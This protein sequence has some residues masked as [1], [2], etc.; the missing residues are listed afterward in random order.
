MQSVVSFANARA[1]GTALLLVSL[2]SAS[3]PRAQQRAANNRPG[4]QSNEQIGGH[5]AAAGRLIVKLRASATSADRDDIDARTDADVDRPIGN[6]PL[7][8]IH[9]RSKGVAALLAALSRNQQVEYAEPDYVVHASSDPNDPFFINQWGLSNTGQSVNG[10]AGLPGADVHATAAWEL[11]RGSANTVVGIVDGGFDVAHDDLAENVWAAPRAFSVEVAGMTVS[12][13]AGTHGAFFLSSVTCDPMYDGASDHATHVAGIAGAAGD[14]GQGVAGASWHTS[15]MSLNFM[16]DGSTGY[17]SDAINAIEFAIQVKAAFAGSAAGNI[18][19]LNNSWGSSAPSQALQD[20]IDRAGANDI[21]FVV[22]AGN[23]GANLDSA[24]DYPASFNRPNQLTV[25]ASAA[26]DSLASFSN[27]SSTSVHLAAPGSN[28]FS[29]LSGGSFGYMS[30]TSMAAPMVAGAAA[31]VLSR[32]AMSTADLKSLL[33]STVDV[34][35]AFEST[36][37]SGGRLNVE[38]ALQACTGSAGNAQPSVTL[39]APLDGTTVS[40][41]QAIHLAA[42]AADSD[43]SIARVDFFAGSSLVGSSAAPPYSITWTNPAPGTYAVTAVATDNAGM[44]TRSDVATVRVGASGSVGTLPSPWQHGDV[45][46]TAMSG[47]A[48]YANGTFTVQGTGDGIASGVSDGFQY[49]YQPLTAD[50][51]IVARVT[52]MQNVGGSAQ[53]GLAMRGGLNASAFE[54]VLDFRGDGAVEFAVR[55]TDGQTTS[56]INTASATMPVW[57]KLA[58]LQA[59]VYAYVSSDGTNW[60]SLGKAF[61][62]NAPAWVGIGV[63]NNGAGDLNAAAFDSVAV[64]GGAAPSDGATGT[65][66]PSSWI[67][68]DVGVTGQAGHASISNGI[69]TVS[70]AGSDIWGTSDS[71]Q[72][73][74]QNTSGDFTLTARIVSDEDTNT[75]AKAG[76]MLR[77]SLAA[78]AANVTLDIRPTGDVEFMT[79]PSTGASETFLG[80][81][82]QPLPG[83]VRL[84]RSGSTVTASASNDGST[85]TTVGS[86][87]FASANPLAGLVVC[88][89]TTSTLDTATFDNVAITPGSSGAALPAP[90]TSTDIGATGQAGHA[91][92]SNGVFTL[93]GAGSDIWGTTDSFQYVSQPVG[94]DVSIVARITGEQDTSAY[95]KAGI[96]LRDGFGANAANVILD[97]V[98]SGGVEFMTRGSDG[99]SET[100]LQTANL[101][102][103]AWVRL[104]VNSGTV[105]ADVSADGSQWTTLGSIPFASSALAGLLVCSHTTAALNTATFDNVSVGQAAALPAPWVSADVGQTGMTGSAAFASGTFTVRGAG[106]DIWGNADG[107]Q[108]VNQAVS[109]DFTLTAR[110]SNQQNT[111]T[112]AKAGIMLRDSLS[113]SGANVLLDMRPTG[114][115]EFMT[116]ASDGA[117][118]TY[119]GTASL[120]APAWV[121]LA[122]AGSTVT[123]SVSADGATWTTIGSA[124]F[125][126]TSALTGLIVCSHTTSA[127]SSATFDSVSL[128]V[129]EP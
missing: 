66:L 57:L 89:H 118:E 59:V 104:V 117:S 6:G 10:T 92:A 52:A 73:V 20:E 123:A 90:W 110:V 115:F 47:S 125:T 99:G 88:S 108:F 26:D 38:A 30:G 116:R 111:S 4:G 67:S 9:S 60:M 127:L 53:A 23:S 58:R 44:Q 100:F 17:T 70:G 31:L 98:P 106:A 107:F 86:I 69:F 93:T 78:D 22:A 83:W 13:P 65:S 55:T 27:V 19:V 54:A 28:I 50:G 80:T 29:T 101:P 63:S 75:F 39:T 74:N 48:S 43:G 81:V 45:G 124:S 37:Q 1:F 46:S 21:L 64:V 112:Y 96:M 94:G 97:V 119:L 129:G 16:A 34:R 72:Y 68:S 102:L 61:P 15:L 77:D 71:F 120:A 79:R 109:G 5:D 42:V 114:D 40:Q 2:A 126:P 41:G 25:A 84:V 36:T 11:A 76:I 87:S 95:A 49:V 105:M 51:E 62:S 56:V 35:P 32:C 85:W 18:R 128:A 7:H 8:L 24:P 103:P 14:N 121:R 113:S 12:C 33:M 91:T 3:A 82:V 122:R